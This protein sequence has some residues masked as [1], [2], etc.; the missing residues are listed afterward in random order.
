MSHL[1]QSNNRIWV[2]IS[3]SQCVNFIVIVQ[4]LNYKNKTYKALSW[5]LQ[6]IPSGFWNNLCIDANEKVFL[7]SVIVK[8]ILSISCYFFSS[9]LNTIYYAL[10]CILHLKVYSSLWDMNMINRHTITHNLWK[11]LMLINHSKTTTAIWCYSKMIIRWF[12]DTLIA[13]SLLIMVSI[14]YLDLLNLQIIR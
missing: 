10:L 8:N 2:T 7:S 1:G 11:T 5:T 3:H 6:S 4:K 9:F 12:T 14:Y 13:N